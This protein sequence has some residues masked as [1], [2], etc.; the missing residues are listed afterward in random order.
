M[1]EIKYRYSENEYLT[2]ISYLLSNRFYLVS[3]VFK[4]TSDLIT[5][6]SYDE[7][8]KYWEWLKCNPAPGSPSLYLMHDDYVEC[9]LFQDVVF[10]KAMGQDVYVV[11]E[12]YGGPTIDLTYFP[13]VNSGTVSYYPYYYYDAVEYFRVRP[14]ETLLQLYKAITM[15]IRKTTVPIT[16]CNRKVYCGTEYIQNI[17]EGSVKVEDEFRIVVQKYIEKLV[18]DRL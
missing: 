5:I 10:N 9:P 12:R 15:Y 3:G 11:R 2:F 17:M 6:R 16:Y 8:F 4:K 18:R 14:P 1:A 13:Y 7:M